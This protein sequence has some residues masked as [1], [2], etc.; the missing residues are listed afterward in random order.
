M[1]TSRILQLRL[2]DPFGNYLKDA[3]IHLASKTGQ[4]AEARTDE[5]GLAFLTLPAGFYRLEADCRTLHRD[6]PLKL[7]RDESLTVLL[8]PRDAAHLTIRTLESSKGAPLPAYLVIQADVPAF[9]AFP[10]HDGSTGALFT[11]EKGTA[12]LLLPPGRFAMKATHGFTYEPEE[13]DIRLEKGDRRTLEFV[14]RRRF[15]LPPGWYSGDDHVHCRQCWPGHHPAHPDFSVHLAA[16]AARANGLDWF[17][18][19]DNLDPASETY[20]PMGDR[21]GETREGEFLCLVGDELGGHNEEGTFHCNVVGIET[22]VGKSGAIHRM[23]DAL[24]EVL[25]QGG[26]ANINHIFL[27][28]GAIKEIEDTPEL[29]NLEVWS[30]E[31][32]IDRSMPVWYEFLNR[33]RRLYAVAHSDSV[34]LYYPGDFV[35]VRRTYAYLGEKPL[36]R[37]AVVS[38]L[39]KGHSF[40]TDGPLIFLRANGR[41]PGER[42]EAGGKLEIEI[43]AFSLTPL[44]E[45]AL[46]A[47]G[48][49]IREWNAS[50]NEFQVRETI[51]TDGFSWVLATAEA[52][53]TI[54]SPPRAFKGFA[55]TNPVW[56]EK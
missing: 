54:Y 47:S 8:F 43:R 32:D 9:P 23:K 37:E 41:I 55:F 13:K 4:S 3:R 17:T 15:D 42:I 22:P 39:K 53:K 34:T 49:K 28:S 31:D 44:V 5:R 11:D 48:R 25:S 52:E 36:S 33:G 12:S 10:Q 30:C 7:E 29:P 51:E 46:V 27:G 40:C 24:P 18:P 1:S 45:V 19:T 50:G 6:I 26:T 56:V 14:L 20:L 2:T 38:S 35:G 21:E 16:R